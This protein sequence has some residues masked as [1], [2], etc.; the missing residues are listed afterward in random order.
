LRASQGAVF[1]LNIVHE[2]NLAEHLKSISAKGYEIYLLTLDTSNLLEKT[3]IAKKSIFVLGNEAQGISKDIIDV[4]YNKLKIGGFSD[5]E[6]LNVAVSC[7]I[8]LHYV[9]N[10]KKIV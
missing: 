5:C 4:G 10:C 7:G 2:V 8:L 9:K 1:H 3:Q 6:S